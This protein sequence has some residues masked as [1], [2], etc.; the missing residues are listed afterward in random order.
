MVRTAA[1]APPIAGALPLEEKPDLMLVVAGLVLPRL[2]SLK[3]FAARLDHQDGRRIS[4]RFY[5]IPD[6]MCRNR[7]FHVDTNRFRFC[8]S[9]FDSVVDSVVDEEPCLNR[10]KLKLCCF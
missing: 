4:C 3:S 10:E 6:G 9:T 8:A 2:S 7:I 1:A 5:L